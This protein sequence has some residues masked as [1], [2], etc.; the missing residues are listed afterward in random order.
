MKKA[1]GETHWCHGFRTVW[2]WKSLFR[3]IL[4]ERSIKLLWNQI[5]QVQI[6]ILPLLSS[7]DVIVIT[8]YAFQC[9]FL[10]SK[11]RIKNNDYWFCNV[12]IIGELDKR[13]FRRMRGV[14]IDYR[15]HK[16][17]CMNNLV[18]NILKQSCDLFNTTKH[19]KIYRFI[20][21]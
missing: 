11:M 12:T 1:F 3:D 10:M 2:S 18:S 17:K 14:G 7:E 4:P 5:E 15:M 13:N 19:T 21:L 8:H 16:G 9:L 6:L 20:V